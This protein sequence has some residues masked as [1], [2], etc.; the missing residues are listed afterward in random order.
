MFDPYASPTQATAVDTVGSRRPLTFA[1]AAIASGLGCALLAGSY[2]WLGIDTHASAGDWFWLGVVI[3]IYLTPNAFLYL[4]SHG[5]RW[6]RL[7]FVFS[8]GSLMLMDLF[9]AMAAWGD[10]SDAAI[11]LALGLLAATSVYC[12]MHDLTKAWLVEI[13]SRR[14]A[15]V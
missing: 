10:V 4:T 9:V 6:A 3:L 5:Q 12:L 13:S 14:S 1:V 8:Q 7:C 2:V 15:G 11:P